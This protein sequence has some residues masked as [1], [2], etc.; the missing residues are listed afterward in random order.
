M[1]TLY[2]K[3]CIN[4]LKFYHGPETRSSSQQILPKR[5][6]KNLMPK[7]RASNQLHDLSDL[8]LYVV[9][10]VQCHLVRQYIDTVAVFIIAP[11]FAIMVMAN[12]VVIML[13]G[14]I[15]FPLYLIIA[16]LVVLAPAVALGELTEASKSNGYS[17]QLLKYWR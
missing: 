1:L 11:G 2:S 5:S 12:Y 4:H 17:T 13:L 6:R 8:D 16:L 7:E 3:S 10:M 15:L 9:L 14:K